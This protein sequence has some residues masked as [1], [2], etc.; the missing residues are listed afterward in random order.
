MK[1]G[2]IGPF[3][4]FDAMWFRRSWQSPC[5]WRSPT[6]L[7]GPLLP[8]LVHPLRGD[9]RT[10]RGRRPAWAPR[11]RLTPQSARS[12]QHELHWRV[13]VVRPVWMPAGSAARRRASCWR[14]DEGLAMSAKPVRGRGIDRRRGRRD[15][16]YVWG[17]GGG[18]F[19]TSQKIFGARPRDAAR[20]IVKTMD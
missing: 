15:R 3:C 9:L 6:S 8:T 19:P 11:R 10:R 1:K 7:I 2:P 17:Y 5:R 20:L 13:F 14:G 4:F 16:F 18:R 12:V